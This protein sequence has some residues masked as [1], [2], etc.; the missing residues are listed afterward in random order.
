[1]PF[2]EI[3]SRS[4]MGQNGSR[5]AP[6]PA[7]AGPALHTLPQPGVCRALPRRRLGDTPRPISRFVGGP[8]DRV[9]RVQALRAH[10]LDA[11]PARASL[12]HLLVHLVAPLLPVVAEMPPP[13]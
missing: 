9:Q 2:S 11:R 6:P 10:A 1:M 13:A 8:N 5:S 12:V 3:E 4:V 7:T